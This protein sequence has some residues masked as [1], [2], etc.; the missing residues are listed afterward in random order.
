MQNKIEKNV[1]FW[2]YVAGISNEHSK[3]D[4]VVKK[5]KFS[6]LRWNRV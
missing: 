1:K 6:D 5:I 3:E 4:H 2:K